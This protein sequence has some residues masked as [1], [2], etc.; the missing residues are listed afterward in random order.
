MSFSEKVAAEV[1]GEAARRRVQGMDLA[2]ATGLS[3]SSMSRRLTG[4]IPFN[5][6]E[7]AAVAEALNVPIADL[8]PI[9]REYLTEL[10]AA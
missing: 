4:R 7:L 8:L 1:R 9:T 3:E 5:V 2:R 10:V 6:D